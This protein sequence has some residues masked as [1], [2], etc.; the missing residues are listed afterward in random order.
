MAQSEDDTTR[1]RPGEFGG[2]DPEFVRRH[3]PWLRQLIHGYFRARIEGLDHVPDQPFLGVGT[4]NGSILM[5]DM[6]VWVSAYHTAGR[7]TPLLTLSHD[8]LFAREHGL[9]RALAKLGGLRAKPESALQALQA[10]YAVQVY[11]GGDYDSS[12]PFWRRHEVCFAGRVGYVRLALRAQVP[13]V[14]VVSIGAHETLLVLS[15]G[16]RLAQILGLRQRFRLA[17]LPLQL[18]LPWGLV[19]GTPPGYLPLPAQITIRTLPP[20]WLTGTSPRDAEDD[21]I[22][23]RIDTE[24]RGVMQVALTAMARQRVLL[25]GQRGDEGETMS[26]TWGESRDAQTKQ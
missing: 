19:L 25:W 14:P 12:K 23:A 9:S 22:V 18:C 8:L 17:A 15:D 4:H 1:V 26:A 2:Y 24:V 6:L 10:G 11:P 3:T 21:G 7:R 13:I 20:I 16:V 5:P